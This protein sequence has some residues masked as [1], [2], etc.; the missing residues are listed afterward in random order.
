MKIEKLKEVK[1]AFDNIEKNAGIAAAM[2]DARQLRRAHEQKQ[3]DNFRTMTY[4]DAIKA[5]AAHRRAVRAARITG[6]LPRQRFTRAARD[7][8]R[9]WLGLS[10]DE[11]GRAAASVLRDF[12]PQGVPQNIRDSANAKVKESGSP[13]LIQGNKALE[14]ALSNPTG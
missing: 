7:K 13:R 9:A 2:A 12:Y 4:L 14:K 5:N 6:E 3:L 11:S 1:A 8:E 10:P